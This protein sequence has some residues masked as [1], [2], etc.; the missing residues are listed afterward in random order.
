MALYNTI[1][2]TCQQMAKKASQGMKKLLKKNLFPPTNNSGIISKT[3]LTV[4]GNGKVISI[5]THF[6]DYT[7]WVEYGRGPGKMPPK[8]TLIDWCRRHPDAAHPERKPEIS[9][10]LIGRKMAKEGSKWWREHGKYGEGRFLTPLNRMIEML[11]KTLAVPVIKETQDAIYSY[12]KKLDEIKV[13]SK[14]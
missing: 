11:T 3:D 6:P 1:L 14:I 2:N 9:A 7:Y 12:A 10:Y 8:G 5:Q 4:T 13:E